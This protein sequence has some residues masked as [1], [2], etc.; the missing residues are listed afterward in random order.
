VVHRGDHQFDRRSSSAREAQRFTQH[1]QL[2]QLTLPALQVFQPT[3]VAGPGDAK[4]PASPRCADGRNVSV[5]ASFLLRSP[6]AVLIL[7]PL[8]LLFLFLHLLL[9]A[10]FLVFLAALVSHVCSFFAIMTRDGE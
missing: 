2:L 3:P 1:I 8:F 6:W 10:F 7:L 9:L 4:Y 5:G